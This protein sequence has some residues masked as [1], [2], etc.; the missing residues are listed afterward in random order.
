M[1][2]AREVCSQATI[3]A[4]IAAVGQAI[5]TDYAGKDLVLVAMLKGATVFLAD[6]LRAID[7]PVRFELVNVTRKGEGTGE[8]IDLTY[9]THVNLSGVN[10][11]ILK[12][13]CHSG[14]TENYLITHLAQQHP[15][16]LDVVALVDRPMLRR[17]AV[18]PRYVVLQGVPDG[19]LVGYGMENQGRW[20]NLPGICLLEGS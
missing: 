4:R 12:D 20:G 13:I 7:G 18:E 17:V 1:V 14:V 15:A 3:A 5:T 2:T 6:L 11:L 19:R 9:A 8:A 10:A 16:S